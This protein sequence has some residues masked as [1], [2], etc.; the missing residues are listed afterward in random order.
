MSDKSPTG[1]ADW[2]E[3]EINTMAQ[4]EEAKNKAVVLREQ[5]NLEEALTILNNVISWDQE[6]ANPRGQMDALGHK[7]IT[8]TLLADNTQD[9]KK[10]RTYIDEATKCIE[11]AIKLGKENDLPK[12]TIAIQYVHKASLHLKYAHLYE[13]FEK[14]TQLKYALE[15][16]DAGLENLPGSKAHRAWALTIKANILH[17]QKRFDEALEVLFD[18]Q[19]CLYEGYAAEMKAQDQGTIKL[20]T[21]SSGIFLTLG[22]VYLDTGKPILAEIC[23]SS[24][25]KTPDPEGILKARKDEARKLLDMLGS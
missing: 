15:A 10:R 11:Q 3:M 2:C 6:N 7:K 18:A 17:E 16:I 22:K 5:G 21:W 19:R 25:L 20:R 9:I 14:T 4:R 1:D 8:L 23:F 24:V 12:G 13:S